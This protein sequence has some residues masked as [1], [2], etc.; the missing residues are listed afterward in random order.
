MPEIFTLLPPVVAILLAF[1]TKNVLFSL[2]IGVL[3]GTYLISLHSHGFILSFFY[4]F[5]E[6]INMILSSLADPWNAGVILQCLTIG[7]LIALISKMGGAKAIAESLSK[8]A[9][10][11]KS[12]QLITWVLGLF[13][14]FD[15]Y[16]NS[17]IVG[18]IMRPVG[19]KMKISREK[20]AFIIDATAAPIAG[21]AIISTWIGYEIS[22]IKDGYASIG[23]TVNAYEVFIQ[24]IPYRFYNIFIMAFI[25]LTAVLAREFGP[26]LK[27]EK[28][29]RNLGKVLADDAKPL[30]STENSSIQ[31][32]EGIKLSIW[33]A[34]IPISSLIIFAFLGFYYS[35]YTEIMSGDELE[36][37]EM[38]KNSPLAFSTLREIFGASD[39]SIVLFQAAFLASIIAIVMAV[40]QRIMGIGEAIDT[41]L[42]GVKSLIITGAILLL[43]WSLS[44]TIKE[45]G[46]ASYLASIL[47]GTLPSFLLPSLI[48]VLGAVISFATGT[49]YGTMGILMPLVIPLANT[50]SSDPTLITISIG[51]VL[52][53]AIFGDHCSPISDTTILSSMGAMCDHLHHVKT[54]LYYAITVGIVTV[55][56]G[57]LPVALGIPVWISL[58]LG[59]ISCFLLVRFVGKPV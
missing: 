41:W 19:D 26:M 59:I 31:E 36:L 2:F 20:L 52:T 10:S 38:I 33:N 16:A 27:A 11:A 8:K 21:I 15:D 6:V 28:R 45:L 23:Q 56:A 12:T 53:G 37:I 46:T 13:V 58:S 49:S 5:L 9:K 22:L 55:V 35:G 30:L 51:A 7:G 50:M 43:A 4:G 39:A 25:I 57:Y 48:F 54:Q 1:I 17:L 24:T 32:K 14:F 44:A 29:A 40:S 3:T 47:S 42:E 18:P 34:I